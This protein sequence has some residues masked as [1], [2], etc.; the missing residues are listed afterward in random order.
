MSYSTRARVMKMLLLLALLLTLGAC[1]NSSRL[2][3]VQLRR[4]N[5]FL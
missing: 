3:A 1:Q 5:Y 4:Y 2:Q